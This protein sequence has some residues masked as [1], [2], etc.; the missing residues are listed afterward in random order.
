MNK[1]WQVK[2][3]KKVVRKPPSLYVNKCFILEQFQIVK[4]IVKTVKIE[5]PQTSF[6]LVFYIT[7]VF[8]LQLLNQ[9]LSI[10]TK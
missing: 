1:N 6:S 5:S 2:G 4:K 8:L 10:I 7:T 3:L 9:Y